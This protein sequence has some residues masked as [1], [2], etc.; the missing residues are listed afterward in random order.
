[1]KVCTEI[2]QPV[3]HRAKARECLVVL[4]LA[5]QTQKQTG[6][7]QRHYRYVVQ[8]ISAVFLGVSCSWLVVMQMLAQMG[9][10]KPGADPASAE[11]MSEEVR[12]A[13]R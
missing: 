12:S 7:S 8:T 10:D 1:M 5:A 4:A 11:G 6:I 9:A 3:K 2:L 13:C